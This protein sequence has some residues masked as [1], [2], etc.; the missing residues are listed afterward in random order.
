M[1]NKKPKPPRKIKPHKS[2]YQG[3]FIGEKEK[4]K[5]EEMLDELIKVKGFQD[6]Q[7]YDQILLTKEYSREHYKLVRIFYNKYVTSSPLS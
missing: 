1:S 4:G 7:D 5:L 3:D 6:S 2:K